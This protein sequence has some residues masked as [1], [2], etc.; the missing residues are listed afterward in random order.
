MSP[1]N[2][3]EINPSDIANGSEVA[4]W[5]KAGPKSSKCSNQIPIIT[6]ALSSIMRTGRVFIFLFNR[7]IN[8]TIKQTIKTVQASALQGAN[9]V[10]SI[11]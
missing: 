2:P 9:T 10:L 7:I 5:L 8:G 1:K 3:N 11:T 6:N 4:P